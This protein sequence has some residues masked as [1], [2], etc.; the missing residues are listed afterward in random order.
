LWARTIGDRFLETL[1]TVDDVKDLLIAALAQHCRH[2]RESRLLLRRGHA[3]EFQSVPFSRTNLHWRSRW[4]IRPDGSCGGVEREPDP[5]PLTFVKH[6]QECIR[7]GDDLG[8]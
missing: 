1:V 3:A 8:R 2:K 7:G 5:F 6:V 4:Q